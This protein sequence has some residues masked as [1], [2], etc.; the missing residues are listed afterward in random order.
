MRI[1]Q[2][3]QYSVPRRCGGCR[4]R[5]REPQ[6]TQR[7]RQGRRGTVAPFTASSPRRKPGPRE[8]GT[9]APSSTTLPAPHFRHPHSHPV[10]PAKAGIQGNRRDRATT[11]WIPTFAGMTI[12][13]KCAHHSRVT[14]V[15]FRLPAIA[16]CL[17]VRGVAPFGT[18]VSTECAIDFPFQ[19]RRRGK[20]M[21]DDVAR[22]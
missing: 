9:T 12:Q 22:G 8:Q 5:G 4:F 21:Q 15:R 6:R 7:R 19:D 16:T 18:M 10:I 1:S 2:N 3:P 20:R 17:P 13:G 14:A 11:P